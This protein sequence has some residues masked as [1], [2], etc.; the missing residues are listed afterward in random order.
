M[1][2]DVLETAVED[3]LDAAAASRAVLTQVPAFVPH[4]QQ[5]ASPPCQSGQMIMS[6]TAMALQL[7]VLGRQPIA[8]VRVWSQLVILGASLG[9]GQWLEKRKVDW[10]G[11]A[12]VALL[13]GIVVGVLAR[14]FTFSKT[15]M[16]WMGF[17]VR[18][19]PLLCMPLLGE[20][21]CIM[22]RIL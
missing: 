22:A 5:F 11:D 21:A 14:V 7:D 2:S 4:H 6:Q 12:G 17:Q 20:G 18:S 16:S 10:L 13:L 15:Y 1:T 3:T 8:D 19:Q 9:L